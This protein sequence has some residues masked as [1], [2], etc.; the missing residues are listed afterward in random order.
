M[1]P[2]AFW[3]KTYDRILLNTA[4]H[5]LPCDGGAALF[6][7]SMYKSRDDVVRYLRSYH[8][9]HQLQPFSRFAHRVC[10]IEHVTTTGVDRHGRR[11]RTVHELWR[12]HVDTPDGPC[13]I[14]CHHLA[15]CVSKQ[16]CPHEPPLVGR[17]TFHGRCLHSGHFRSG[18]DHRGKRVLVVGSGNSG[19][20]IAF[21]RMPCPLDP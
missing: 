8:E 16:R 12:L 14:E 3:S 9:R 17:D 20:E 19:S 10:R 4:W 11:E 7:F 2:G 21:D 13:C 6:D 18:A 1:A 5:G 15:L